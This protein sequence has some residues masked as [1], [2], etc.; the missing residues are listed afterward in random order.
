MDSE[1]KTEMG[2]Y[3]KNCIMGVMG[4]LE[5]MKN[6]KEMIIWS[7]RNGEETLQVCI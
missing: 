4:E 5:K 3:R 1:Y 2:Q 7:V 6:T